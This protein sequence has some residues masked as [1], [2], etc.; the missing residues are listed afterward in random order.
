MPVMRAFGTRRAS[1]ETNAVQVPVRLD[2]ETHAAG[3]YRAVV[4]L[5]QAATRELDKIDLTTSFA[6]SSASAPPS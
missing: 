3:F 5:D 4:H 2:F 1:S 6:S